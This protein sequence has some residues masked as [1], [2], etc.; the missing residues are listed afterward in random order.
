MS[1][2]LFF[3]G[4]RGMKNTQNPSPPRSASPAPDTDA[5]EATPGDLEVPPGRLDA[6]SPWPDFWRKIF[7]LAEGLD[8]KESEAGGLDA[9]AET[10]GGQ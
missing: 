7:V 4:D 2:I 3:S 1:P 8:A 9:Q 10:A 6:P 5:L